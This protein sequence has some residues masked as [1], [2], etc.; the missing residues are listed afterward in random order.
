[1]EDWGACSDEDCEVVMAAGLEAGK[2]KAA[3]VGMV[4][5]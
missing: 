1:M 3:W 5:G 4:A 2:G